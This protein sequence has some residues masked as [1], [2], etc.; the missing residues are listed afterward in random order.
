MTL[1]LVLAS[2]SPYRRLLL[3]RLRIPFQT[4]SPDI[5]ESP[6]P[7]ETALALV[8][9]LAAA[10]AVAVSER[11]PNAVVIGSDQAALCR[12]EIVGKPGSATASIA[13]LSRASGQAV[14]FLTAVCVLGPGGQRVAQHVD[15]TTVHF[16]TLSH[17]EIERYVAIEQPFD[18][19]GAFKAE[20]LG[21]ALFERIE[22]QDPTALIGLPLIW[23]SQALKRA[24]V[25]ALGP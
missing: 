23:L 12:D 6:H 5:D 8:S 7:G 20:G 11:H 15:T 10:K 25:A 19:A 4:D 17:S 1:P 14:R 3:E 21:V 18:S 16:R 2:G 9:R 22:S 24:G 13:Q